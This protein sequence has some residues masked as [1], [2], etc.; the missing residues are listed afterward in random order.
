MTKLPTYGRPYLA[1]I[2]SPRLVS[3]ISSSLFGALELDVIKDV[4]GKFDF[5]GD[6]RN[7]ALYFGW[8]TFD[9]VNKLSKHAIHL[10]NGI[11]AMMVILGIMVHE[12]LGGSLPIFGYM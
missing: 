9:E 6:F 8:Y 10:N 5:P 3:S 2:L 4:T 1:Q 12:Q 11:A 7:G